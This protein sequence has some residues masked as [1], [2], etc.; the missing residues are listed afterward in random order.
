MFKTGQKL[1][2]IAVKGWQSVPE[3]CPTSGPK[4]KEIVTFNG[5]GED[6]YLKLKEYPFSSSSGKPSIFNP[7][8]F[9]PLNPFEN[10]SA[11]IVEE[12]LTSVVQE[13]SEVPQLSSTLNKKSIHE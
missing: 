1:V 3:N 5:I 10:I 13:R 2:C 7:S 11:V 8:K 9:R 4:Y 6:G 12:M